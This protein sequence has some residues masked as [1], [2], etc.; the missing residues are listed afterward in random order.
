MNKRMFYITVSILLTAVTPIFSQS[1][2]FTDTEYLYSP[3]FLSGGITASG[4]ESPQSDVLN[5]AVSGGKQRL[6]LDLSYINIYGFGTDTGM[7]H[8]INA[9][10][11]VPTRAGVFSGS[12]RFLDS[13]FVFLPYGTFGMVNVSFGKDL[14]PQFYVGAGMDFVFGSDWGLGLNLGFLH[15]PGDL[16]FLKDFRWGFAMR[17]MGKGY[18]APGGRIPSIFTP[19]LD[20]SFNLVK[21]DPFSLGINALAAFPTFQD[22]HLNLGVSAL[23]F[24]TVSL[25]GAYTFD[26]Q[27]TLT[28]TERFPLSFGISVSLKTGSKTEDDEEIDV[29]RRSEITTTTAAAPLVNGIWAMGIGAN[30]PLGVIDR[31]PPD[32]RIGPDEITYFSPDYDGVKDNLVI[33]LAVEDERYVKG[34]RLI[35]KN[36]SGDTVRTIK[37]KDE[38]PENEGFRNIID[39]LVYVKAGITVP[40]S[41]R[42]DGNDDNGSLVPDG[43]YTYHVEAWDDNGNTGRTESRSVVVDTLDPEVTVELPYTIFSPNGDGNKDT[44][45]VDQFGSS[46]DS[47]SAAVYNAADEKVAG[48]SWSGKPEAFQWDGKNDE[49]IL[50]PDGVYRYVI[51]STDKAGNSVVNRTDNIVINTEETPINLS[52]SDA[53]FSPDGNGIKDTV[54]FT[55]EAPSATQIDEWELRITNEEDETVRT[56]SGEGELPD[57]ITFNGKDDSGNRLPE[58][59]YT[60]KL[61][62]L[63]VNGNNPSDDSPPFNLDLTPPTVQTKAQWDVFSPNGDG[64]KDFLIIFQET[65]REESWVG[66]VTDSEGNERYSVTWKGNAESKY[67]WNGRNEEGELLEDGQY[68][69]QLSSTDLAGN[70]VRSNIVDFEIDTRETPV[71][72]SFESSHFSPNGDGRKDTQTFSPELGITDSVD[73]YEIA[74]LDTG[75]RK[76][77]RFT[78]EGVPPSTVVWDGKSDEGNLVRDGEYRASFTAEYKHGNKPSAVTSLFTVDTLFPE[79]TVK[80]P[81]RLFSPDGDGNKDQITITQSSSPEDLWEGVILDSEGDEVD[82]WFWSGETEDLVWDGTDNA[83]NTVSDGIYSYRVSSEDKAGNKTVELIQNIQVDTKPTP[84][85]V[86]VSTGFFSPNGDGNKD[87]I[88]FKPVLEQSEGIKSWNLTVVDSAERDTAEFSGTGAVP[89]SI[90]WDGRGKDRKAGEGEYQARLKVEYQK[91]NVEQ[92]VSSLFILDITP[93]AAS[94]S[95]K[96]SVFSPNGDGSKDE[97][98]FS[99]ETSKEQLWEGIITDRSGSN[100]KTYTWRGTADEEFSWDGRNSQG[101]TVPDGNYTYTLKAVDRAGNAGSANPVVFSVDTTRTPI[102]VTTDISHFSPNGDGVKETVSFLPNIPVTRGI[103]S[104]TLNVLND[105]GSNIRTFSGR[106]VP[107]SI[108]WNGKNTSGDDVSDGTYYGELNVVYMNGNKPVTRTNP[109]VL[110]TEYPEI[111]LT[112]D[113]T[114]FSPEGDGNLDSITI[115]QE[116]SSEDLWEGEI[117]DTSGKAIRTFYWQGKAKDFQWNGKDMNGNTIPDGTYTYTVSSVDKAGNK[118][119]AELENITID[120]RTTTIFTTV[121]SRGFSPNGD[122]QDDSITFRLYTGLKEGIKRWSLKM[123]HESA[124]NERTFSG[125]SIPPESVTWNGKKGTSDAAEGNY[126]ALFTV[127]YEKGNRPET[128]SSQFLLDTSPPE[129]NIELS[130]ELFS[131]DDDGFNDELTIRLNARD[132]SSI[133]S[134]NLTIYDPVGKPFK[135]FSGTG[136]PAEKIIW[137]G[138]SDEGELV[139]AAEDYRTILEMTDRYGNSSTVKD[140]IPIDVLVIREGDKLKIRISSITFAP[141]TADFKNVEDEKADR[142]ARTLQRLAEIFKKYSN[143]RIRIEGHAVMVHYDDPEKGKKEQEQELI[144]L[145][146]SRAEAVK[147]ALVDF[148]MD[149]KRITT[150][151]LGGAQPI[152]PFS[153]L[154]NRWKNRRVE[155]ILIR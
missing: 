49:G 150:E 55:A 14:F 39:R 132:E 96:Y 27:D 142:N 144:P 83:G 21:T 123:E 6:T 145:S 63:Y 117:T 126:H 139:Q 148:G 91:G 114:L 29:W 153:D 58:S 31:N 100:V 88:E 9:G 111:T 57:S 56:F 13:P 101:K 99:Q 36:G 120:T 154:E 105:S 81:T 40:E 94:A 103:E 143:Y 127:E 24:N 67:S 59:T 26:L 41:L 87:S 152:V 138:L 8:V 17:G 89:A 28:G 69:Y 25:K 62:L 155:F 75:G 46:E 109:I 107:L 92:A 98:L 82:S 5:P 33:P 16:G 7:G 122:G 147:S 3:S 66:T 60:A 104:Y 129:S 22:V 134:W 130:P 68:F 119:T 133:D 77:K 38:R 151:G 42:W 146:K 65:S 34:Y 20:T 90:E 102:L 45:M 35:I 136:N 54:V 137:D 95:G 72:L 19:V 135:T 47:W 85:N 93:P 140:T 79:I 50:V 106:S 51:S 52:V 97:I 37:N 4:M 48:F 15:L 73:S 23:L 44:L 11:T 64:R 141:N 118:K 10:V 70:S 2:T 108:S 84:V 125:T 12:G 131:P 86:T 124:G 113:N 116:S 121:S 110:D 149:P 112:A 53:N 76:I 128:R 43:T 18:D 74:V 30:L 78:G 32:I 115:E 61:N 80:T 1:I 71:Q